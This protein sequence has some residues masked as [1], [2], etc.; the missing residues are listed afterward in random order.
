MA[1][2]I[3]AEI[4][5]RQAVSFVLGAATA[6]TL[7]LLVQYRAPA[8]GLSYAWTHGQISGQR[9]SDEQYHRRND[10]AHTVHHAPSVAV[11]GDD[12]GLHQADTILKG[13]EEAE[14]FRG[15][16]AA[17]SRAAMDDGTVIITCVNQA[18]VAPGSLLDLFLESFRIGDG[19]ARL[20][21]HVLVVTMDPAAH[22]RC[23][24]VHRHCYQHA[25]P[26]INPDFFGPEEWLDLVWSKLKLQRRILELGY[27]FLFTDVDVMWLRDPFKH[28]TAYADMTI[29]SDNYFGDPDNID[30]LP[31][32]GFFHMKPNRRTIAMTKLWHES[33]G[34]YPG[35]NEQPVFNAIKARLVAELGVRLRYLDPEHMGGF[36]SYGKDLGKIVT[37]HANCCVGLSKKMRDLRGV[38]DDWRNYTMLPTWEKHRAKWTVAGACIK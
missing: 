33:R 30:N 26:G 37:M 12:H 4:M 22:A 15:L 25:I 23:L 1:K 21:P 32:T 27:G 24:A 31:N 8:E 3:V 18:W 28:V 35:M 10:T 11:A 13:A 38:L 7:V 2:A 19:T 5:A 16:A 36:C 20:L 29:S 6:L 34:S 17:V 9:S 14:E